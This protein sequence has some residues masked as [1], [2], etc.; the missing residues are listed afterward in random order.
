LVSWLYKPD[1]LNA[2]AR[3][4][5]ALHQADDFLISDW[6]RFEAI[7]TLRRNLYESFIFAKVLPRMARITRISFEQKGTK[8]T[9]EEFS[10]LPLFASVPIPFGGR[11]GWGIPNP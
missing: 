9:K 6:A 11:R 5:F 10:S 3:V 2:T 7:N 8:E 1:P 4:W